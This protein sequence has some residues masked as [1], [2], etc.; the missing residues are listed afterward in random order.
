MEDKGQKITVVQFLRTFFPLQLLVGH[1]KYNLLVIFYWLILFLIV[2]DH[3]GSAFGIPYLFFSPEY[4]GELS[5]IAFFYIGFSVGGFT[6]GFNTYSYIKIGIHYPFLLVVR[7]PFLKFCL[8]N[9]I[10]PIAFCL[11]YIYQFAS[12]QIEEEFA[13][14]MEVFLYILSFIGGISTFML[15]SLLYFFPRKSS[16]ITHQTKGNTEESFSGRTNY[17]F[18]NKKQKWYDFFHHKEEKSYIYIGRNLRLFNSRSVKHID[19]ALKEQIFSSNRLNTSLFEIITIVTFVSIGLFRE[20]VIFE[21]P[22]AMSVV[23][24]M[25][26]ILMLFSAM[27]SWL[28][29]WTYPIFFFA[30]LLMDYLS[31]HT[32]L[33][34]YKNS[35]YG[36]SYK[37]ETMDEYSMKKIQ[38]NVA[39]EDSSSYKC[40]LN[41][42][43]NWKKNTG[44]D[45]PKLVISNSSGGGSRSALW[46]FTVLQKTDELTNG[47]LTK[48]L[49]LMTGASGGMLGA[50][51]F[52]EILLQYKKG[53]LRSMFSGDYREK[54]AKDLLNKLCFAASTNDLFFRYQKVK[55]NG[56]TYTKDRGYAFEQQLHENTDNAMDHDLRYYKEFEKNATIPM[57][58][59]TP[60]I[61]NDGRRLLMSSQSLRFM[62]TPTEASRS[63]VKS[64]ECIDYQTYFKSNHPNDIRFSTV[65]RA[66]A[67]FPFVLPMVT[68]PTTPGVQLMDAGIRDNYG[69]KSMTEFL[70]A[71]KDWIT[72]NTSGVIIVQIRD[73]KKVLNKETYR[74]VSMLDKIT[75]PFGNMYQNFARTQDFD[76]EQ[77]LKSTLLNYGCP[78]DLVS[79]NL[80]ENKTDRISLSWHLTKNEKQKIERAFR[81]EQNQLAFLKLQILLGE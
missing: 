64:Y 21:I 59:F 17:S 33:F 61:V 27:L 38:E 53:E 66:Q 39:A 44:E 30:I 35:A 69:T 42:L 43:E 81:S 51:Y 78:M 32:E 48:H 50:A 26:V 71:M 25:T 2:T 46:T 5:G 20:F 23:L 3:L 58:I 13:S 12:F 6:M 28:H 40:Y 45:K 76:Q 34:T 65:L 80:R 70:Y 22:A 79:F 18:L 11:L 10:I 8:N 72:E 15:L 9:S 62:T 7:K 63:I 1:L 56:I 67:T 75:L 41:I 36:L 68:M 4:L 74:K 29:R 77:L 52:R 31:L 37:N 49:H 14:G 73:T 55:I 60:T 16:L 54:I 19:E 24:L 47:N 57:M